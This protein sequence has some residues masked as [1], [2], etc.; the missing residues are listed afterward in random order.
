MHFPPKMIEKVKFKS[1]DFGEKVTFTDKNEMDVESNNNNNAN[2]AYRDTSAEGHSGITAMQLHDP[3]LLTKANQAVFF[4]PAQ[5]LS[6][7]STSFGLFMSLISAKPST[8]RAPPL[9][10][11]A[12]GDQAAATPSKSKTEEES[13]EIR[14]IT[15]ESLLKQFLV[16]LLV[17]LA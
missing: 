14:P 16:C 11:A 13:E 5:T 2:A 12:A 6:A 8:A 1:L 17:V 10:T 7:P 9:T 4:G 15:E 3:F